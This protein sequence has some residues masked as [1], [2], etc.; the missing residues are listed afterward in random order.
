MSDANYQT[1]SAD[2]QVRLWAR[3]QM[4]PRQYLGEG[5]A[6]A[7]EEIPLERLR[8]K[9]SDKCEKDEHS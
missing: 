7:T 1:V 2:L 8:T 9:F 5:L 3:L 6:A 4:L